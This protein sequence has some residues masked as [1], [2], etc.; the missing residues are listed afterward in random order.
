V[1]TWVLSAEVARDSNTSRQ[2]SGARA[3]DLYVNALLVELRA[4]DTVTLVKSD[5][6]RAD[7]VLAG[8]DIGQGE[9]MLSWLA[10]V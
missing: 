5:D 7:D 1:D 10:S 6:L 2:S 9:F 4:T 8:C 3:T